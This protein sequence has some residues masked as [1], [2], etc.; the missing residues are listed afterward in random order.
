MNSIYSK[1]KGNG[2]TIDVLLEGSVF[3]FFWCQ[4]Q[5]LP[6]CSL[7]MRRGERK[8]EEILIALLSS[9]SAPAHSSVRLTLCR[10][11]PWDVY[12]FF[13]IL[14]GLGGNLSWDGV[15]GWWIKGWG[16]GIAILS[17]F[18]PAYPHGAMNGFK[19]FGS[20]WLGGKWKIG[21]QRIRRRGWVKVGELWGIK[22][23]ERTK[24]RRKL[25]QYEDVLFFKVR[26]NKQVADWALKSVAR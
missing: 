18:E 15:R 20:L 3:F 13:S 6:S 10:K 17:A 9:T 19:A 22:G 5:S 11:G 2:H 7:W 21:T 26:R 23:K 12:I 24:K 1:N 8:A 4:T 16:R 14:R 25:D